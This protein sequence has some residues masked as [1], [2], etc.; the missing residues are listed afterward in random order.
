[1][2][3]TTIQRRSKMTCTEHS[4]RCR[5]VLAAAML[6]TARR[7]AHSLLPPRGEGIG[8]SFCPPGE[9]GRESGKK[10]LAASHRHHRRHARR[11]LPARRG[12]IRGCFCPTGEMGRDC[13][14]LVL[15]AARMVG[16]GRCQ[17]HARRRQPPRLLVWVGTGEQKGI[18]MRWVDS[19][20]SPSPSP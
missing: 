18:T 14:N 3:I 11:L 20:Q 10:V 17:A 13:G 1:M 8:E 4:R 15:P 2:T 5:P 6:A 7:S 16:A 19:I 9:E 12:R